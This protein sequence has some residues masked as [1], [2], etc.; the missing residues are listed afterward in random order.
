MKYKRKH[1]EELK[2]LH[3]KDLRKNDAMTYS[4]IRDNAF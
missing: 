1:I 2:N 4:S 3:K